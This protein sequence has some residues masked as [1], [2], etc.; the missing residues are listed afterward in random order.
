MEEAPRQPHYYQDDEITLKELI[1][2]VK[3][4]VK[5]ILHNWILLALICLPI[6][7]YKLY[8]AFTER[9]VYPAEL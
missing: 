1:L 7:G 3:E 8:Q 5:E 6:V 2:K 9:T 4:Y